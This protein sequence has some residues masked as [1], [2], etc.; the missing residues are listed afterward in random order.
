MPQEEYTYVDLGFNRLLQKGDSLFDNQMNF[1]GGG[2]TLLA[3]SGDG[4]S[5]NG[6]TN[7]VED[8]VATETLLSGETGSQLRLTKDGYLVAGA[9]GYNDG[10]GFFLG[11]DRTLGVYTFFIGAST[12]NKLTW[13]GTTLSVTGTFTVVAGT[14]AGLVITADS[15]TATSGGNTTI[16]SSRSEER[17]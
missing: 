5:Y 2:S 11:W 17:R 14:I 6:N 8:F 9:D 10:T 3:A 12:G 7:S 13:D 4:G 1:A 16:V 15:L